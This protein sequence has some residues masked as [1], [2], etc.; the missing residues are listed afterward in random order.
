M[1]QQ[2]SRGTCSKCNTEIQ[3]N[4]NEYMFFCSCHSQIFWKVAPDFWVAPPPANR[5]QRHKK[6]K[7]TN[8]TDND[9]SPNSPRDAQ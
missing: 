1:K 2:P 5:K 4:L 3:Y 7:P 6:E 9:D 8:L